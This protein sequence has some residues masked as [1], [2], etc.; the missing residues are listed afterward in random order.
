MKKLLKYFYL[1]IAIMSLIQIHVSAIG[2]PKDTAIVA[3]ANQF[4]ISYKSYTGFAQTP[5]TASTHVSSGPVLG[6]Y[7]FN[8]YNTATANLY[9]PTDINRSTSAGVSVNFFQNIVNISND[10]V[11]ISIIVT[12]SAVT[13]AGNTGT[14]ANWQFDVAT[15]TLNVGTDTVSNN[16]RPQIKPASN[17]FNASSAGTSLNVYIA[18]AVADN[19]QYTG[20][21]NNLYGGYNNYT[22]FVSATIAGPSLRLSN[23]TAAVDSNLVNYGGGLNDLVPGAKISYAIGI[24]NDGIADANTINVTEKIP[25][26]TTFYTIDPGAHNSVSYIDLSDVI[27]N[28][29]DLPSDN[30]KA[31]I[32]KKTLLNGG[33]TATFNYSV[34]VN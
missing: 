15:T 14:L 28:T 16:W 1:A 21:N 23:R 29:F 5:V 19:T 10:A 18:N 3:S 22:Y 32:F 30:V 4:V 17:A 25:A 9:A 33:S 8:F 27:H 2:T 24:T 34:T 7:G 31:L 11:S 20:F 26:N 13:V 12:G 6:I